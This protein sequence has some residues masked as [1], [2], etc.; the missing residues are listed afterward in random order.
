MK[1]DKFYITTAIPYVNAPPHI[2]HALEFVQTDILARYHRLR[3]DKT[4]LATGADENALKN[5]QAAEK[6]GISTQKLVDKNTKLFKEFAKELNVIVDGFDRGSDKKTHWPGVHELWKRCDKNG[7]IY[8]K[9][10]KGLYCVGHEAFLTKKELVNGKCPD[11]NT[12][13]DV[14]EEENYFFR[15]SKYQKQLEELIESDRYQIIPTSRKNE[16]LNFIKSGLEDFSISRTKERAKD[17][18]IPVPSDKDQIIYVWFDALAIYTTV[19]GFGTNDKKFKIWWPADVHVI[20]KDIIRFHAVYWPAILLSSGL[21]LPKKLLVHGFITSGG[22]KMSKSLGNIVDPLGYIKE[23][24]V[25]ALRYYLIA[26]IPTTDDGDFSREKFI[27]RYN[28]DLADGLGNLTSRV[29][30]LAQK[31]DFSDFT[32]KP[33]NLEGVDNRLN[34]VWQEY[35]AALAN[36]DFRKTIEAVWGFIHFLDE[37]IESTKPWQTNDKEVIYKLL[38][39]LANIGWLIDPFLPAASDKIIKA[40]GIE[41]D[42]EK[43]W[44]FKPKKIESLFPKIDD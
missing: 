1:Q 28:G 6:E 17:W 16:V 14:V 9:S 42:S 34:A 35:E 11:H 32:K 7:D 30:A 44:H 41:K 37:Y 25:D 33:P 8:K 24:G 2:G 40:L 15:L 5:V 12:K 29:L 23:F 13:P 39:S 21:P 19:V 38:I 31:E 20:G 10:Y 43:E 4:F 22:K 36:F 26:E 27:K 3:G 18:G